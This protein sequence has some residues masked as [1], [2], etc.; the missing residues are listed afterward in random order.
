MKDSKYFKNPAKNKEFS[1]AM[2]AQI[3]KTAKGPLP[4]E[5]MPGFSDSEDDGHESEDL[6]A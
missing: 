2:E 3:A 6:L 4:L 5:R 1:D